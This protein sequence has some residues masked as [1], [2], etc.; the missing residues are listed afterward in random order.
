MLVGCGNIGSRHLQALVK[1]PFETKIEIIEPNIDA[2][3]TAKKRLNE[4]R[5]DKSTF[6]IIWNTTIINSTNYDLIIL[7]TPSKNRF[8]LIKTLVDSGNKRFLIEKMV[9]QSQEEY[10]QILSQINSTNSKAWV[11]ASRRYFDS[12]Q[13]IKDL[14]SSDSQINL[15]VNAG[16]MGLGSNA[17]HFLDLFLWIAQDNQFSLN[18]DFLDNKILDNKRG[19]EYKEF[20]GAI[21][22]KSYNNSIITIN[23]SQNENPLYVFIFG[24]NK[25]LLIDETNE[26]L[27]DLKANKKEKFKVEFQSILT[28][29]IVKDI[30]TNDTS[31]L[32]TL[33]ESKNTHNELFRIF[34]NHIKKISGKEVEKCPIT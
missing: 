32:P 16:N 9:C 21:I 31:L 22:G 15:S 11:N 19:I 5:Y 7:A 3:N 33:E 1:L 26:T 17:I 10:E 30:F 28:T 25:S 12:Y 6:S 4:I 18:G 8:E 23:F 27:F 14:F 29:K 2:Q 20:S 24:Q 13:K 34:N